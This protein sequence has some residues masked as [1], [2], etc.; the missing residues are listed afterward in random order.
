MEFFKQEHWSG[1]P[2]PSPGNL[3]D[4]GIET[5]SLV[6]P[7]TPALA[8]GFFTTVPSGKSFSKYILRADKNCHMDIV[9]YLFINKYCIKVFIFMPIANSS[10][11]HIAG[12]IVG[13]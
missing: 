1:L 7:E 13:L 5:V 2:F 11:H 12:H 3:L 10:F 4:P 6:S 8:G 9:L